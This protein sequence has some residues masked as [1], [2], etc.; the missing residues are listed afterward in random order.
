[1]K[2]ILLWLIVAAALV[3]AFTLYHFCQSRLDVTPDV[4]REIDRAKRR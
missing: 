4:Q 1:V 2:R 3:T